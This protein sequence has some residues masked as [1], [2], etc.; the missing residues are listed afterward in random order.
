V[1]GDNIL[2]LIHDVIASNGVAGVQANGNSA[3]VLVN[4]TSILN[5][6]TGATSV[7]NGGRLLTYGNN[8]VVGTPGSGFTQSTPLQ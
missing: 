8:S 4:N 6:A 7:V 1:F 3:A 2:E 5:N